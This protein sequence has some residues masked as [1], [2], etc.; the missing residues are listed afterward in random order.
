MVR[1]ALTIALWVIPPGEARAQAS[2][3]PPMR[4]SAIDTVPKPRVPSYVRYGKWV[5]LGGAFA[6]G[7]RANALHQ[8]ANES[9]QTLRDRCFQ[10]TFACSQ[11]PDG[12]YADPVSERLYADTRDRDHQAARYLI[13]AEVSFALAATGFIW[14][15]LKHEDRT[16]NIPFEPRVEAGATTTRVGVAFRF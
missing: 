7:L 12:R 9:Y 2:A 15:L 5:A 1:F 10:D 14:E 11:L 3:D 16:P 8:D 6:L 13:G 4:P